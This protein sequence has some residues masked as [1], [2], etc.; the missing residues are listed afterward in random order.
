M[1]EKNGLSPYPPALVQGHH[2]DVH[3]E[4]L[5][6]EIRAKLVDRYRP[7]APEDLMTAGILL[8]AQK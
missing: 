5:V 6:D 3:H 4:Q 7:L 8:V 1:G 2:Y